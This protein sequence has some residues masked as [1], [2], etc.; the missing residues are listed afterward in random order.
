MARPDY[1]VGCEKKCKYRLVLDGDEERFGGHGT[2]H[3]V[4]YE[5]VESECDGKLYSFAYDLPPYGIAVFKY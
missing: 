2:E 4:T 5:A 1:R 3:P